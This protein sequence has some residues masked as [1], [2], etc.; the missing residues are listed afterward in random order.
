MKKPEGYRPH[1]KL[2]PDVLDDL[3]AL[4]SKR[5]DGARTSRTQALLWAV[6]YAHVREV[7]KPEQKNK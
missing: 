5:L 1:F 4:L 6:R 3:A 7:G 2:T